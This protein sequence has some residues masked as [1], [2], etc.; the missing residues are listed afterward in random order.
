MGVQGFQ[1][2]IEK[3]CLSAVMPVE[4]QKLAQGSLV[5]VGG[6]QWPPQTLLCLL[7]DADNCLHQLYGGFYTDWDVSLN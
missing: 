1:D 3:H 5:G 6:W 7:I 4:L 2:Y